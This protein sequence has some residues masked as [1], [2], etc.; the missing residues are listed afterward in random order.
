MAVSRITLADL[1]NSLFV[2]TVSANSAVAVTTASTVIYS[3]HIDNSANAAQAEYVKIYNTAGAVTVGT[4]VPD[5]VLP[6]AAAQV[7][8][9]IFPKGITLA[10]GVAVSTVTTGGTGGTTSPG[11]SLIVRITYT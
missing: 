8:E 5:M 3:I 9:W 11:S 1:A 7:D 6:V 4:T 10:T 2:D